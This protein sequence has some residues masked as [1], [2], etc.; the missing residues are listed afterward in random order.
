M[1]RLAALV[2]ALA[3]LAAIPASGATKVRI[4]GCGGKP[5]YKPKSVII[6]CGDGAF[7]IVK[8]NWSTWTRKTAVGHG[9]AKVNTCEPNCAQGKFKSYDVKLTAHKP[10]TCGTGDREFLRLTYHFPNKKP[11]GARRTETVPRPCNG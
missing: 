3:L 10:V 9:I 11:A 2:L 6:A 5:A 7:R 4:P 1:K 8:L